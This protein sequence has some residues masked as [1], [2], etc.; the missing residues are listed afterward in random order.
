M[1]YVQYNVIYDIIYTIV[2]YVTNSML[3]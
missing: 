1:M 3:L 2:G